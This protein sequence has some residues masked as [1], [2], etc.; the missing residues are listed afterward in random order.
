VQDRT[1]DDG[2]IGSRIFAY[3]TELG[4]LETADTHSIAEKT[5]M[6]LNTKI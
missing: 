5:R 1:K 4:S 3:I 6:E 2:L